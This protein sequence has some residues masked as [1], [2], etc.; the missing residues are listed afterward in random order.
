MACG[1]RREHTVKDFLSRPMLVNSFLWSTSTTAGTAL[2]S[3]VAGD[4]GAYKFPE[5]FL[6]KAAWRDKLRGF[7]GL[8][9]T[10]VIKVQV[11]SMPFQQ[12]RLMLQYIPYAKYLSSQV[13]LINS[14]LAGRS[15]C[16]HVDLDLSVS[17]ECELRVPYVS[18]HLYYNL[19]TGQGS[20]GHAYLVV[21][22][23]LGVATTEKTSVEVSI[24]AHLE[25]IDIQF[26]TGAD[27]IT[28]Q[29]GKED[30]DLVK[31]NAVS[32]GLGHVASGLHSLSKIP[33][34]GPWL[35]IPA[36]ITEAAGYVF[37]L[38][39][40][41][42]PTVK[43]PI[44]E[45]K[46]RTT[47]RMCT[48]DGADTS[49]KLALCSENEVATRPG[50]AGTSKDEMALQYLAQTPN[51]WNRFT[52]AA[53]ATTNTTLFQDF[54]TPAKIAP[55]SSTITNRFYSTHLGYISS[56]F[57]CWRGSIVYN[58]KF[59]K[60]KFHS[61]RVCIYYVPYYFEKD[62][63]ASTVDRLRCQRMVVDL[64]TATEVSF[65]VPYVSSRPWMFCAPMVDKLVLGAG[66]AD[67][68]D[69]KFQYATG[70]I[71]VEVLN[72]L[73]SPSSVKDDID[74]IVEVY[75]G[76][77]I[78]FASPRDP[79][80]LPFA[81]TVS[82]SDTVINEVATGGNRTARSLG[83]SDNRRRSSSRSVERMQGDQPISNDEPDN[84][85][86]KPP[87]LVRR[88]TG[89]EKLFDQRY[90]KDKRSSESDSG[91]YWQDTP[92]SEWRWINK[93]EKIVAQ[94]MS[95]EEAAARNDA[96]TGKTAKP[97]VN[98][99]TVSNWGPA[100]YCMGE[101]VVSVRQL[102]KRLVRMLEH[103]IIL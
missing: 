16:P 75:G 99:L 14:T 7:V 73:V 17:T 55:I 94:M 26:P 31:N 81:G 21:Y 20:F 57:N 38:F 40:W 53:T 29:M 85:T 11:N 82:V 91:F 52:W 74:V 13:A 47:P 39:G 83:V 76:E 27:V 41:S 88:Q 4:A 10:L 80:Y 100:A 59:V 68:G 72:A 24:W 44:T 103:N 65:T 77:D 22:S 78:E 42:K 84:A 61:G 97:I 87:P 48:F 34:L 19:V 71:Y 8:R 54:V 64:R 63:T 58:F 60:T 25:D 79:L 51:Y 37:K 89:I 12:G 28:V 43:G 50:M 9:A 2:P 86:F 6:Q 93:P 70:S 35:S 1:E 32:K 3:L 45:T 92:T 62:L 46:L 102:V 69:R 5:I 56:C 96:Q 36:W 33:V 30:E 49:H 18:P 98:A 66:T 95:E 90:P 23:P 15:G 101:K 67:K